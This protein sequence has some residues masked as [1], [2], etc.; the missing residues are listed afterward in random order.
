MQVCI[1]DGEDGR[2]K[3]EAPYDTAVVAALRK[4]PG[5]RWDP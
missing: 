4:I 2:I 3:V 5:R 1:R